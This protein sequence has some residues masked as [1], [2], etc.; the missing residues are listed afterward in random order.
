MDGIKWAYTKNDVRGIEQWVLPAY[1]TWIFFIQQYEGVF[2]AC[3]YDMMSLDH[4]ADE[5][6]FTSLEAAQEWLV[7][8]WV[9][10][11]ME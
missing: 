11:R 10:N 9:A 6:E 7:A 5:R 8:Q 3:Y 4:A 2:T 1:E